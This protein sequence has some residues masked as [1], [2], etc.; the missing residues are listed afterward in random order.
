MLQDGEPWQEHH[1][2]LSTLNT[3][4]TV[5]TFQ[6]KIAHTLCASH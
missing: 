5:E 3:V 1:V 6:K 2:Q 4:S